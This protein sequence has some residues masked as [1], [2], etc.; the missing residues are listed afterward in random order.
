MKPTGDSVVS[1][2]VVGGV[3][4]RDGRVLMARRPAGRHAGLW[5]FPGGKVEPGEDDPTALARELLEELAVPV[6]VRDLVARGTDGRVVLSCY[7]VDLLA[8]PLPLYHDR[9][10]WIPLGDLPAL[11]TPPADRAT[12]LALG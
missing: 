2:R 1:I 3:A 5:E 7:R 8:D 4:I 11:P 9:L 6:V 10:A 12:V